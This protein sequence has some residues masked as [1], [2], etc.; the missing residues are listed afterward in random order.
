MMTVEELHSSFQNKH[1]IKLF[2]KTEFTIL[3]GEFMKTVFLRGLISLQSN[4]KKVLS[5]NR[6]DTNIVAIILIIIIIIGLLIIFRDR[7][8]DLIGT[9]FDKIDSKAENV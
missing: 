1:C 8:S 6:G 2:T 5:E 9:L 7:I 4:F 3:G